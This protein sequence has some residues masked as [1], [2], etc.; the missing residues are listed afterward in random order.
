MQVK[1]R[2]AA[3]PTFDARVLVS[4]IVVH[5]Q[6]QLEFSWGF[7]IDALQE[8]DEFLMSVL[9]HAIANDL[10]I[11]SVQSGELGGRTVAL[12]VMGHRAAAARFQRQTRL[13]SIESLNLALLIDAENQRFIG[14]I[15]VQA[16]HVDEF[17][18]E[19]RIAA[20]FERRQTMRLQTV[21]LPDP[22]PDSRRHRRPA[23]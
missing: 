2:I 22:A 13:R 9:G 11:E 3:Q 15:Q 14:W 5:D 21:A 1:T 18:N 17:L 19:L 16:D 4:G 8:T 20:D 7:M 10:P 6:V 23:K 12:V